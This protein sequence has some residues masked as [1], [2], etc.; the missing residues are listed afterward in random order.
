MVESARTA[1]D[2]GGRQIGA[3]AV[4]A[5]AAGSR[6]GAGAQAG[7]EGAASAAPRLPRGLWGVSA[8]FRGK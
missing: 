7:H 5:A 6:V 8:G 2:A 4:R 3:R 1:A